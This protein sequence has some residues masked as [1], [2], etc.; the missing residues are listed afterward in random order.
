MTE[1][2]SNG[3]PLYEPLTEEERLSIRKELRER[4]WAMRDRDLV[5]GKEGQKLF[6]QHHHAVRLAALTVAADHGKSFIRYAVTLN[7]GAMIALLALIGA[8]YG[9]ADATTLRSIA[10]FAPKLQIGIY[11]FIGG[12]VCAAVT[13]AAAFIQ[14]HAY[15]QT[16]FGEGQ[17][18][19]GYSHNNLFGPDNEKEAM[20]EFERYDRLS[21]GMAYVSIALGS[22]SIFSF[23]AGCLKIMKAF[24]FLS[25]LR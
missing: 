9:R 16:H 23:V 21:I 15:A 7:G 10:S 1:K 11:F 3:D 2:A 5:T 22:A 8:L 24:A 17:T 18:A 6:A 4:K 19:N 25:L 20:A 12:L 13:A 14:W